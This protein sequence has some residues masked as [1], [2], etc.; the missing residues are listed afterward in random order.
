VIGGA[1]AVAALLGAGGFAV[2]KISSGSDGGAA[3]PTEVGQRFIASLGQE[4]MLGVVD[5]LLPGERETMRQPLVDIVDNLKRLEV[6]DNT[7]SLSEVGGVDIEFKDI[8]VDA[9]PTNVADITNIRIT[10]SGTSTVDG[11]KVPIGNLLI[12]KAFDG[13][14]PEMDSG[15]DST[16]LNWKL[17]TVQRDGRWY[18]SAFYSIAESIRSESD[19]IPAAGIAPHGA[20]TPEGAVQAMIDAVDDLDLEAMIA[21]LNPNEAEALQRYAP[22]F[23]DSAQRDVKDQESNIKF[24]GTKFTVT[25]SGD[26]RTVS[27]DAFKMEAD[28]NGDVVTV[29]DKNGCVVTT[30]PDGT[31]DSCESGNS[32]DTALS[33]LG[34]ENDED[35]KA[36]FKTVQDAFADLKPVGLTV[37]QVN[38]RWFL[39]P[40][41]TTTDALNAVMSALDKNELTDIIDGAS[42]LFDKVLNGGGIF[43]SGDPEI[44]LP[45]PG[46]DPGFDPSSTVPTSAFDEC[47]SQSEYTAFAD[48][49]RQGIDDGSIN[50][51]DVAPYFRFEECGAGKRY[52]DGDVYSMSDEE[53][54]TFAT[55]A[56]PCFQKYIDDGTIQSYELTFE[57]YRPDCLEGKNWYNVS[58][59]DYT[60]RVY[61]CVG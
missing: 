57:L 28:I 13:E 26:R 31:T 59:T 21:S 19:D 35:V 23:I 11:K 37:Q 2:T 3:S 47:Y 32:I 15:P 7:A 44:I 55:T 16:D 53:F 52:F 17:A 38:G 61:A 25:G 39:S 1:V 54:T 45:D 56:A 60:D 14:R 48:C 6:V 27:V 50:P 4:D 46:T 58:D 10:G 18:L 9:T 42:N 24:S 5:L 12:D 34:L 49:V 30:T 20:S 22:I 29:E 51:A 8:E 41:G 33:V 36:Y 40:I 43:G